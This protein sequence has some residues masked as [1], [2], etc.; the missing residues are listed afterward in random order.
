MRLRVIGTL[1]L[2]LGV[3]GGL[4]WTWARGAFHRMDELLPGYS[5]QRARQNEI[6][7]GGM[8]AEALQWIE[9]LRNPRVQSLIVVGVSVLVAIVCFRVASLLV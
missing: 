7:M 8:V 1:V 9:A 4:Y 5:Q 3:T 2:L 6:L